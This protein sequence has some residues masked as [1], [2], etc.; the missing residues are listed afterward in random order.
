MLSK[1]SQVRSNIRN[2]LPDYLPRIC[3]SDAF[4]AVLS[5]PLFWVLLYGNEWYII[6]NRDLNYWVDIVVNATR[7]EHYLQYNKINGSVIS[8]LTGNEIGL[9]NVQ[10]M[11]EYGTILYLS[12]KTHNMEIFHFDTIHNIYNRYKKLLRPKQHKLDPYNLFIKQRRYLHE[13]IKKVLVNVHCDNDTAVFYINMEPSA[14]TYFKSCTLHSFPVLSFCGELKKTIPITME[15]LRYMKNTMFEFLFPMFN[16]K[17][18]R[19]F[20]HYEELFICQI[21]CRVTR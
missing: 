19:S 17:I 10:Q 21:L 15:N 20:Y 1:V 8:M 6:K 18:E 5:H 12:N 11:Y 16:V 2:V 13:T 14:L 9:S 3:Y 7:L 4:L